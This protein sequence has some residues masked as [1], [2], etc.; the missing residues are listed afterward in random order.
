MSKLSATVQCIHCLQEVTSKR[1]HR[2]DCCITDKCK[3]P[4]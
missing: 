2:E 1:R 4:V 3:S